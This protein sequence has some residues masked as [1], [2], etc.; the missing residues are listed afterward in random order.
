MYLQQLDTSLVGNLDDNH[1]GIKIGKK[2]NLC[3]LSQSQYKLHKVL[4]IEE[5]ITY[6]DKK[7]KDYYFR[8]SL[9]M[10]HKYQQDIHHNKYCCKEKV[11]DL[12]FHNLY[13][14]IHRPHIL[15]KGSHNL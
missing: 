10:P 1:F 11:L 7:H 15:H 13:I 12:S 2:D 9:E 3:T 14:L 5:L 6:K 4:Y 8:K